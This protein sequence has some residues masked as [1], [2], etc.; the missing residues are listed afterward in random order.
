[1]VSRVMSEDNNNNGDNLVA[2]RFTWRSASG[3]TIARQW[4]EEN[5]V[6]ICGTWEVTLQPIAGSR[7]PKIP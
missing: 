6:R 7:V 3:L 5:V 4:I 2:Y 1:M